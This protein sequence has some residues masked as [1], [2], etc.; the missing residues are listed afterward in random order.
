MQSLTKSVRALGLVTVLVTASVST[1]SAAIISYAS[2]AAFDAAFPGSVVENWD[3]FA[4]GTTFP[5]GTSANGITYNA[6]AGDAIVTNI[7]VYTTAPNTLGSTSNGNLYFGSAE[8]MTF[9]FASP[10]S[11]FGIDINTFATAVGAYT[12]TTDG[13]DVINSVFDPFPG[14]NSGQFVG[15]SSDTPFISVTIA[16]TTQFTYTLD[17]LRAVPAGRV[18][19]PSSLLL[20]AAAL[21]GLVAT[22]RTRRTPT[23]A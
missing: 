6:S 1:A 17:T 22:A 8:S 12:A 13:A 21:L 5:N 10:I 14:F 19:E 4:A 18:P 2:R 16:P 7:F 9:T 23:A 15:F 20:A 3:G 11:A